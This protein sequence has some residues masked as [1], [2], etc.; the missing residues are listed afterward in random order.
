MTSSP[1]TSILALKDGR[2]LGYAEY[3]E[4]QGI[5]VIGFHGMPGSRFMLQSAEKAAQAAGIRLIA[6]ERPGYGLTQPNPY[7]TLQEYT[8]DIQELADSLG[9][10]RF[11]IMGFSGGGPYALACAHAMP[12]R[13]TAVALVSGMGPLRFPGST[14]GMRR[15]NRKMFLLGRLSP[16][17]AGC[18]ISRSVRSSENSI[19]ALVQAGISPAPDLSPEMF[20]ILAEDKLEAV[21]HGAQGI[22]FDMRN[23]WR[24]WGFRLESIHSQVL[25]WHGEADDLVPTA[26]AHRIARHIPSCEAVF[27]PGEGHT[28]PLT[29]H[30]NE[31]MGKIARAAQAIL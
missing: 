11:G 24:P 25:L 20:A 17:L 23:Y 22:S 2:Q 18:L 1:D 31:I 15:S 28:D 19:E 3:G 27:Y 5:P 30:I 13:L 16:R 26:I 4:A 12:Q 7:G 9:I 10:K 21:R 6:P 29:S 8:K 14:A